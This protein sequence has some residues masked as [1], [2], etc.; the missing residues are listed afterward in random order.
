MHKVNLKI[1]IQNYL[2]ALNFENME[3]VMFT[4]SH[5]G[6]FKLENEKKRLKNRCFFFVMLLIYLYFAFSLF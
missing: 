1:I 6:K 4:A 3:N 5:Y 2:H